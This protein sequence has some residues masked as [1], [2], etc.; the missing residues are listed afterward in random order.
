MYKRNI[1]HSRVKN[2][3]KFASLK[4]RTS[5][6]VESS[7]EFD[8]C[9]Y[10]E[11]D[12]SISSYEMQ[13]IGLYYQ[14]DDKSHPYTPDFLVSYRG[15]KNIYYE[16]KYEDDACDVEF[17][18]RFQYKK[19]KYREQELD[20]RLITERQL[21]AGHLLRN[22]H[23]IHR[24][25]GC[26]ENNIKLDGILA[27][28]KKYGRVKIRE[29]VRH[30]NFNEGDLSKF[31]LIGVSKGFIS[32]N[33]CEGFFTLDTEIFIGDINNIGLFR[34]ETNELKFSSTISSN[35]S[36]TIFINANRSLDMYDE[37]IQNETKKRLHY[38]RFIEKHIDGGWTQKNIDPLLAKIKPFDSEVKPKWRVVAGWYSKYKSSNFNITSIIPLH[39][40]KGN[41]L[42]KNSSADFYFNKAVEDKYLRK[43][44]VSIATAYRY[45]TDL[46]RVENSRLVSGML[47]P[48]SYEGFK[49]RIRKLEPY[50]VD[51]A[52]FGRSYVQRKYKQGDKFSE[53][54]S[55][56]ERV[57]IDHTIIDFTLL[58]ED[59]KT[60]IGRP[61]I[62]ALVDCY[63]DC[64][65]GFYLSFQEPSYLSIRA[66]LIN[67]MSSKDELLSRFKSVESE[68]PCQGKIELLVVDN[69]AE[70]WSESLQSACSE[71]G[72]NTSYNPV[73]KPWKKPKVERFFRTLNMDL[74]DVLPRK[75]FRNVDVKGDYQSDKEA[76]IS[77]SLF[78]EILHKWIVDIYNRKAD[79]RKNRVP[80]VKW[81][82]GESVYPP[83]HY[84]GDTLEHM[85]ATLGIL[86]TRTISKDGISYLYLQYDS[87]ELLEY[88][89]YTPIGSKRTLK[90]NIKVNPHDLSYIY[91]FLEGNDHY[92]KVPAKDPDGYTIGL[93]LTQ[94][95]INIKLRR[96]MT[97]DSEDSLSLSKSRIALEQM[98]ADSISKKQ[99]QKGIKKLAKYYDIDS[100]S[101]KKITHE[102]NETDLL[103]KSVS[104]DNII[105]TDS[106]DWDSDDIEAF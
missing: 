55:V 21:R 105:D 5:L 104:D 95:K 49:A 96:K 74:L 66:A 33:L 25:S 20:L 69:G 26:S 67:A 2:I 3:F 62:T 40:K 78:N 101:V 88:R 15:G 30:L 59:N 1:K 31:V 86:N 61:T 9:F 14:Y 45:Y 75:N 36:S 24:Y 6:T 38:I 85:C 106:F 7:L 100:N 35:T 98:I 11:Y 65:L 27:I 56:L 39:S 94:H 18:H 52:R 41:R 93:T 53:P 32:F 13:P 82:E 37:E 70:F 17:Y 42:I 90:S 60:V 8:A 34:D 10:F 76:A 72:I 91:V 89:K 16:I 58:M 4:N 50:E 68:W 103:D 77:F 48:L 12:K 87:P 23:L 22:L 44:R 99:K 47:T 81:F 57:E 63:S 102:K 92:I 83:I 80:I 71:L 84:V 43:E 19:I 64:V 46:I 51:L 29:L 54:T 73:G 97:I 28:V 79:A